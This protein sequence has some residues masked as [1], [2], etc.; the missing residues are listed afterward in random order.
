MIAILTK[1]HAAVGKKPARVSAWTDRH[2]YMLEGA[3]NI[4]SHHRLAAVR[5]CK[6]AGLGL[7]LLQAKLP[8]GGADYVFIWKGVMCN[9]TF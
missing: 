5:L 7:N 4:E 2:K 8:E 1:H 3:Q 6:E 9:E